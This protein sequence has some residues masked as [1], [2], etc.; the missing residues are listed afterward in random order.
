[1]LRRVMDRP[2]KLPGCMK[3]YYLYS[4]RDCARVRLR[5]R[6]NTRFCLTA[7]E[8]MFAHTITMSSN[9]LHLCTDS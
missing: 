3:N 9:A 4:R 8:P 6:S 5:D 7:D 2:G 1:M